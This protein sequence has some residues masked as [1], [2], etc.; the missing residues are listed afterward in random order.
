M[1]Q[2]EFCCRCLNEFDEN[3]SRSSC[4]EKP[5]KRTASLMGQY[6]CPDCGSMVLAGYEHPAIC[7]S[8]SI[9]VEE[10]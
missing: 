4:K 1:S 9:E 8:C 3:D 10:E 2:K 5:E 7:E 6:H